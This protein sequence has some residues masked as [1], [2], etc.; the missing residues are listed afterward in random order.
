MNTTSDALGTV[1]D[2]QRFSIYDGPGI[3]TTVF[4]KGC[5]LSCVWCHNPE[6]LKRCAELSY[7]AAS[8][9]GCGKCVSVCKEGAHKISEQGHTFDRSLCTACLE[10]ADA[11]PAD[12]LSVIG[13]RMSAK[14]VMKTVLR[15]RLFYK[16]DGGM[17]VSGGEPFYQSAFLIELLRKAKPEGIHTCVETSGAAKL[18]DMLE[19]MEYVDLFLYDCKLSPGEKHKQYIGSDGIKMHENLLAIDRAGAKTVLR[20]PII[21][22][23][24]DTEQHFMYIASLAKKL[25]NLQQI[26]IEPY[27]TIGISKAYSIGESPRY[28]CDS[29][30]AAAFKQRIKDTLMPILSDGTDVKVTI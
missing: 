15:D 24:N 11:C 21:P 19:A 18:E 20:C 27:H 16:N 12:A 5:P 2:I 9:I 30:D 10:C 7:I 29:F 26:N 6:S 25:S 22:N 3:R 28:I 8:C 23:V 4:L 13:K 17:T 1:F 14:E